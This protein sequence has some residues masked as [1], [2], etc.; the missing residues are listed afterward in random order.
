MQENKIYG[1]HINGIP[2]SPSYMVGTLRKNPRGDGYPMQVRNED[3]EYEQYSVWERKHFSKG[4]GRPR[5]YSDEEREIR[6]SEYAKRAYLKRKQAKEQWQ[7][8][9]KDKIKII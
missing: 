3:G 1:K 9:I 8:N 7:D 5:L 2:L 4:R 6:K